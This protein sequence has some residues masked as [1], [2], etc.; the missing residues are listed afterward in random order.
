[1]SK[2]CKQFDNPHAANFLFTNTVG[3]IVS[4]FLNGEKEQVQE[5]NKLSIGPGYLTLWKEWEAPDGMSG[6]GDLDDLELTI[7]EH[8]S[9]FEY[10]VLLAKKMEVE[11]KINPEDFDDVITIVITPKYIAFHYD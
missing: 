1:M 2:P 11:F 6:S 8:A 4:Q 7:Q 10:A 3:M 5:V 9:A